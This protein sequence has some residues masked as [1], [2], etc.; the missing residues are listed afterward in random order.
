MP[1]VSHRGEKNTF[2]RAKPILREKAKQS[3]LPG[4]K[5]ETYR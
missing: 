3:Y 5:L 4:Q 1:Y 2:W